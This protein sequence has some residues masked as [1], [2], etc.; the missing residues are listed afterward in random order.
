MSAELGVAIQQSHRN[1]EL[2]K[3]SRLDKHGFLSS[4]ERQLTSSTKD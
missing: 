3:D 2:R 1:E 4:Y